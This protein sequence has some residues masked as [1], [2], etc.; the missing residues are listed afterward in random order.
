MHAGN[1]YHIPKYVWPVFP[2]GHFLYD[3]KKKSNSS[4][5]KNEQQQKKPQKHQN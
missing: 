3:P 2:L 1:K 5:K 4:K